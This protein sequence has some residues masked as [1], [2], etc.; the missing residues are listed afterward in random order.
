M[1]APLALFDLDGTLVD[2]AADLVRT[3][4]LILAE[5][6]L[7]PVSVEDA[8]SLIG[9]GAKAM[10]TRGFRLGGREPD[11]ADLERTYHRFLALYA[12][13]LS[14]ESR[15]YPG[16]PAAL[17]RLA[18]AGWRMAVCTNKPEAMSL[19]LLADLGLLDRFAAVCGGDTFP[20]RKPDA[21]HVLGTIERAGGDA[22][23]ALMVGDSLND[24]AAAKNAHIPVIAIGHGY[25]DAPVESYDPDRV[26]ARFD[27]L[28]DAVASLGIA[29][30]AAL[31]PR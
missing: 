11:E 30:G 8:G 29:G 12:D 14:V 9:A 15:P 10:V 28:W 6:G 24:I 5:E 23:R 3:L 22:S 19:R 1:T 20:V 21:A 2:T 31:T 18:A 26:I 17:D 13:N 7:A 16:V 4:N 27:E 25:S